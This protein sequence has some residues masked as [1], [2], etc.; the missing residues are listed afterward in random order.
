M[1]GKTE[2]VASRESMEGIKRKNG[3]W[4]SILLK[5]HNGDC[6]VSRDIPFKWRLESLSKSIPADSEDRRQ[7]HS[8]SCSPISTLTLRSRI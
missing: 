7:R 8:G 2:D 1:R 5:R 6:K 3:Q 4:H